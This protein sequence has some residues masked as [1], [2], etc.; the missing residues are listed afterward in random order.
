MKYT[1]LRIIFCVFVMLMIGIFIANNLK[2]EQGVDL[3]EMKIGKTLYISI[4]DSEIV[5]ANYLQKVQSGE[6]KIDQPFF[7]LMDQEEF[8]KLIGYMKDNHFMIVPGQYTI[9]QA[10]EFDNGMFSLNNGKKREILKFSC[11]PEA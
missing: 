3:M 6:I 9:N 8:S 1:F 2:L 7:H 4:L 10:C 11:V 5:D